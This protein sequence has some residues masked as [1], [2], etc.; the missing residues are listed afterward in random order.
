MSRRELAAFDLDRSIKS[1]LEE[2]PITK[3]LFGDDLEDR[4]KATKSLERT[5]HDLRVKAT[6]KRPPVSSSRSLNSRGPSRQVY[7]GAR[8][9][10][11][12]RY[13]KKHPYRQNN[14]NPEKKYPRQEKR[15]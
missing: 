5:S 14:K 2:A 11:L 3:F 7:Q 6:N 15:R 1:T 10:G 12:Q 9:G 8:Q 4:V 13:Q